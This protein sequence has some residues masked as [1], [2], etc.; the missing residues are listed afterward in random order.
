MAI[1]ITGASG[2]IYAKRFLDQLS[3]FSEVEAGVVF[4]RNA[5]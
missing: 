3:R 5:P 1:G 4:S 2:S